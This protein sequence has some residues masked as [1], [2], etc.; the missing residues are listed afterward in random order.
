MSTTDTASNAAAPDEPSSDLSPGRRL[1]AQ[2]PAPSAER[3]EVQQRDFPALSADDTVYLIDG[4]AY[5]FRAYF[6]MF[7][8]AQSRGQRFSRSDGLPTGA[9]MTFCNMLW[10]IVR[11]G[12]DGTPPSRIGVI[13][14]HK[15]PTFRSEIYPEYKANRE[16]P[17]DDLIPQFPLIR[18][19]VRA[20][21]LT[22]IEQPGYEADD[23]I[24]TYVEQA[25]EAGA[26][27]TIVS[28]DKDLMQL[29]GPGVQMYDPM[30]GN[31]RQ[32]DTAAVEKK[33]GVG[34]DRVVD[35]QALAGD[36]TDN[37]PGVPGIGI[38]TA[39]Q[40][41]GEFGDLETLLTQADTI[42]QKKR[43][44]NLIEFAEQARIS[45]QLVEL[46]RETPV[47]INVHAL[48]IPA[49]DGPRLVAFSK[50]MEF[51]TFT[52]RVAQ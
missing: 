27:I 50:A 29:I 46:Y 32:I 14:D 4:A 20:F 35:V 22:P 30:P 51:R 17:P 37:V 40:L 8:A 2:I 36:S 5:I 44:E 16:A 1:R 33:F 28:G 49:I 21:N 31:E 41:I 12:I 26:K 43:R 15:D 47:E 39:A 6:A 11:D 52:N 3:P 48:D 19:A 13:F 38:K 9:V 23:I 18:H 10:K 7:K 24:A 25:R 34:P 42:K 45:R